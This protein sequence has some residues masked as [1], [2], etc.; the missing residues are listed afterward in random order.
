MNIQFNIKKFWD[1]RGN[2][3]FNYMHQSSNLE[4]ETSESIKKSKLEL[5]NMFFEENMFLEYDEFMHE[6]DSEFNKWS[7][8]RLNL[9]VFK[10]K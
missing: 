5:K 8:T 1:A 10:L 3:R 9:M 6:D 2:E 7:N 4:N